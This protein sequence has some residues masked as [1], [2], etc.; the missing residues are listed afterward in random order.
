MSESQRTQA[1]GLTRLAANSRRAFSRRLLPE[2][3]TATHVQVLVALLADGP[4]TSHEL[5]GSLALHRS[6]VAVALGELDERGLVELEADP[7]RHKRTRA[8]LNTEGLRAASEFV[9]RASPQVR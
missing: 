7:S 9:K 3:L 2:G 8:T 1:S 5:S 4:T 6:R